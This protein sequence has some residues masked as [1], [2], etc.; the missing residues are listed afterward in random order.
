MVFLKIGIQFR[1]ILFLLY[2]ILIYRRDYGI[3][4]YLVEMLVDIFMNILFSIVKESWT[5]VI[6][7]SR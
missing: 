5:V 6:E 7:K 1:G 4:R 2:D 3:K